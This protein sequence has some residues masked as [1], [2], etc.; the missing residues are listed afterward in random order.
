MKK[1][2]MG[3]L[4]FASCTLCA[5]SNQKQQKVET[6]DDQALYQTFQDPGHEWRGKPFWSWN[7]RLEKDELIRQLHVFKEMGMGGAFMHSRVGLKT[8][9]LG[10]NWFELTNAV[11]D[12]S[13]K[14]GMEAFLYDEDRWPSGSAGGLVTRNPKYRMNYVTL[15]TMPAEEFKWDNDS[16]VSAFACKLDG[17][18]YSDLERLTP[19][20][21]MEAYKGKTVLKFQHETAQCS[22]GY[23]GYTYLDPMNPEA[24]D[25]YIELTHE[26]YKKECGKRLGGNIQGIFT[27]EPHRGGLFTRFGNGQQTAPWTPAMEKSYKKRFGGDLAADLPKLFLRENG[28]RVNEVKWNFCELTQEMFLDNY[29]KPIYDWCDKNKMAYTGHVLHENSFTCQVTMQGSLMRYYEYMHNPGI[30]LLT[31]FDNAYWVPKQL[32]SVGR[33][34]GKKWLLSELYGCTGWQFNFANHKAV[35]DWQALF[36]INVRCHHLSWY[37]MEGE[38]KRDYPASI[39]Y[40]SA[41]WKE[42]KFVEDYFSRLGVM[43]NQGAPVCDV[44][45]VNPIESVWSQVSIESFNFLSANT[46]EIQSME[47]KYADL[48]HWLAGER[49]D[50]DYGDEE[51]MSRLSGVGKDDEGAPVFR[52]GQAAYRTVLVG[53]METMRESTLKALAKFEKAGGKIIFMGDAPKYV[54]VKPSQEPSEMASRNIQVDYAC[55]PIV[56]ALHATIRPTVKVSDATGKNLPQIFGQV[57]RDDNRTYVVLMNMDRAKKLDSVKIELPFAGV[58]SRWDC[59]TGEVWQ[60]PAET[61]ENGSVLMTSFEPSEEKVYTL[62]ATAP[63][64]AK[65][66]EQVTVVSKTPLANT[67]K[68]TLTEPNICVL[69]VATWNINKGP[70]QPLTEILKID[71]AVRTHF[72]LPFRGGEMLQ[73]WYAERYDREDYTKLLG[74]IYLTFPFNVAQV[75]S[76]SLFFCV[77]TPDRFT[78]LVNDRRLP[79]QDSLCGWFIDNSIKKILLPN[80]MLRQGENKIQLIANFSRN[81]DLEAAYL[82]GNFGVSLKGIQRTL[83]SL[84]ATLKVGD[85]STQ[86]LPFYSGAVCYQIENLPKPAA[87]ERLKVQ[88]DGF[89]GGCLEL[90]NEESR[91]VCGWAPYELDLTQVAAKGETAQLKVVLTRR[92]TF[93]PLH[94]LPARAG[95]Y[96]PGNWTT[97]GESFTMDQYVLLP[98]GLTQQPNLVVEQVK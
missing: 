26:K 52:V 24:T 66:P 54:D 75:P 7:G 3:L 95:A 79:A 32:S 47:S 92:N 17:I 15:Y 4:L 78:I 77:E 11:A 6:L 96:G 84:P 80:K 59:K 62:A 58:I 60:Q 87:G 50:F 20:S 94:A 73:P 88:M 98:A 48:F 85:I 30:D 90:S 25:R 29:A 91:Q 64:F 69:D 33:Q 71:R 53:N 37:T 46:P 83:T 86:G 56:Q 43:L 97:E 13:E 10:K 82:I 22:D 55:E 1:S 28:E 34:L 49:I 39:F 21:K 35:G 51:M 74:P 40:Q 8:E 41:W 9:Y 61:S 14:L 31:E 5:C 36:G 45:I 67:F 44:L 72:G 65:A 27:D 57:R 16:I 93:G 2:T 19:E 68:Y 23:N 38:A 70:E 18:N 42:Y 76:D 89:D 81:L 12:E 63:E